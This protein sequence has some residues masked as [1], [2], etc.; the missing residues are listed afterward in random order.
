MISKERA[1]EGTF[2]KKTK[3]ITKGYAGTRL[4]KCKLH[5]NVTIYVD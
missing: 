2:L 5:G 4:V 1:P 3:E